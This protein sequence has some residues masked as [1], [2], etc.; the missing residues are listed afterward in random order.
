MQPGPQ[1]SPGKS[2]RPATG[3]GGVSYCHVPWPGP[4]PARNTQQGKIPGKGDAGKKQRRG[5]MLLAKNPP[6]PVK[7]QACLP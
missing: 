2:K 4:E 3:K 7:P 5:K 1:S 6:S